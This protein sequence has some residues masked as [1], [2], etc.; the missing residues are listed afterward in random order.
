VS[1]N[2]QLA[3]RLSAVSA[4]AMLLATSV[5][6][7]SRPSNET[8]GRGDR[9]G[10][11]GRDG[12]RRDAVTQRGHSSPD[13]SDR[14]RRGEWRDDRSSSSRRG[15]ENRQPYYARGRVSR[16]SRHG[17]GYRVWVGGARYPFYIP[18]AHYN[19]N[20]FRIGVV[21]NLG[22]YYNPRGYYDYYD[23]RGY[24]SGALRGS[25]E[26]VDYRRDTFV[27][28]N[29][30]TGS[31]VTVVMRDR[32]GDVRPGDYVELYGDWSRSGVFQAR[33]VDLLDRGYRR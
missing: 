8:R 15:Y 32:R 21:V 14:S 1:Q 7:D 2:K 28:R 31:F 5:F 9:R 20:R 12:G 25:V 3:V 16:V 27:I 17:G 23:G 13:R 4:V 6:A 30:A 18:Q 11:V 29:D 19:R 33:D 24:S 26:S 10:E 22:G